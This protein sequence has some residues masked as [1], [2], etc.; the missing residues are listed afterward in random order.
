MG[1]VGF[2]FLRYLPRCN[3]Q[4]FQHNVINARE[5]S[6]QALKAHINMVSS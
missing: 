4:T 2:A 5:L 6:I 1:I 3:W